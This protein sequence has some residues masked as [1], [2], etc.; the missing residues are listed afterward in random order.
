MKT[1]R[2]R[3]VPAS[4]PKEFHPNSSCIAYSNGE[5]NF[6]INNIFT[7]TTERKIGVQAQRRA[8]LLQDPDISTKYK[9]SPS[10][11]YRDQI[12][13]CQEWT[14]T[15]KRYTDE[16]VRYVVQT[17]RQFGID[18]VRLNPI[19]EWR[20][21]PLSQKEINESVAGFNEITMRLLPKEAP[22]KGDTSTAP[23]IQLKT[24]TKRKERSQDEQNDSSAWISDHETRPERLDPLEYLH[25]LARA[26]EEAELR[27]LRGREGLGQVICD[28]LRFWHEQAERGSFKERQLA[29]KHLRQ[30]GK[31]LIPETR[32]KRAK[33]LTAT[34]Y[35]LKKFYLKELYRLY[36]VKH[37]VK[38]SGGP[39]NF[40]LKVKQA[41]E[42]Y[43]LP[44]EWIREFLGLDEENKRYRQSFTPKDMV[45]E[46]TARQFKITH[47]S[48]SNLLS[49]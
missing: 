34:P 1:T 17:V 35:E 49:S 18:A 37:F 33:T 19:D 25:P 3:Y 42:N 45:R 13:R 47:Q 30:F 5:R 8:A 7:P 4:P 29:V 23:V 16:V 14:D 12:A 48:V 15:G 40:S 44:T 31:A 36:H 38:S 32:G 9:I 22:Q 10:C 43:G 24:L 27:E 41:S 21:H 28:V 46:L 11:Y 20:I 39:R 26:Q 6:I 2:N